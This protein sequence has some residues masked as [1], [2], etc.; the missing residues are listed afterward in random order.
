MSEL[1]NKSGRK[2]ET[3]SN[4]QNESFISFLQENEVDDIDLQLNYQ[5]QTIDQEESDVNFFK[6][7]SFLQNSEE[8]MKN[9]FSYQLYSK[10]SKYDNIMNVM[11]INNAE[12]EENSI[13][14]SS[15]NNKVTI[16]TYD[17][18][19]RVNPRKNL[20]A[21]KS[22]SFVGKINLNMKKKNNASKQNK[23]SKTPRIINQ[24]LTRRS[25]LGE[26]SDKAKLHQQ[27]KKTVTLNKDFK[28]KDLKNILKEN[29]YIKEKKL[30]IDNIKSLNF[31]SFKSK[32]ALKVHKGDFYDI[33][34]QANMIRSEDSN[35][36]CNASTS[37]SKARKVVNNA[38]SPNT[39]RNK[40]QAFLSRNTN[41]VHQ[42]FFNKGSGYLKDRSESKGRNL[43]SSSKREITESQ[44][45]DSPQHKKPSRKRNL[46]TSNRELH[47]SIENKS[48]YKSG[49][50][51]ET[52]TSNID[53][54]LNVKPKVQANDLTQSNEQQST[55]NFTEDTFLKSSQKREKFRDTN[56]LKIT[57]S[58]LY[59]NVTNAS[60]RDSYNTINEINQD[61][62]NLISINNCA[63]SLV[64]QHTKSNNYTNNDLTGE[65]GSVGNS[66]SLIKTKTNDNS[67]NIYS[68]L[69]KKNINIP[70]YGKNMTNRIN[71]D[72]IFIKKTPKYNYM[73]ENMLLFSSTGK[74]PLLLSKDTKDPLMIYNNLPK[75]PKSTS[76]SAKKTP[77]SMKYVPLENYKNI[78]HSPIIHANKDKNLITTTTSS[79]N[80]IILPL[81]SKDM[82]Q[83]LKNK[84]IKT[85]PGE[86]N[87]S[88]FKVNLTNLNTNIDETE[89]DLDQKVQLSESPKLRKNDFLNTQKREN[90]EK[91]EDKM[92]QKNKDMAVSLYTQ[93]FIEKSGKPDKILQTSCVDKE[94]SHQDNYDQSKKEQNESQKSRSINPSKRCSIKKLSKEFLANSTKAITQLPKTEGSV[95]NKISS[96]KIVENK[97]EKLTNKSNE[98]SQGRLIASKSTNKSCALGQKAKSKTSKAFPAYTNQFNKIFSNISY[99]PKKE[100]LHNTNFQSKKMSTPKDLNSCKNLTVIPEIAKEIVRPNTGYGR[101]QTTSVYSSI[102]LNVNSSVNQKLSSLKKG[103]VVSDELILNN[104]N[105][106]LNSYTNRRRNM[107]QTL[108]KNKK[109]AK[110]IEKDLLLSSNQISNDFMPEKSSHT[111]KYNAN[112]FSSKNVNK[113]G[114]NNSMFRS[115]NKE[116][117]SKK[118]GKDLSLGI[119]MEKLLRNSVGEKVHMKNYY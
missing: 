116:I 99:Q 15:E 111:P 108:T 70:G 14:I 109:I 24:K 80:S 117:M 53:L 106:N 18:D 33:Q 85:D 25:P 16:N 45:V 62:T 91:K 47:K 38:L 96:K 93:N 42:A 8:Q 77:Y 82:Y 22:T 73:N 1:Q 9:L 52:L 11:H 28:K 57:T 98:K 46:T 37:D 41:H 20:I 103:D 26:K 2:T 6:R 27:S 54:I 113:K 34:R 97:L 43:I 51:E 86:Q 107:E 100:Y 36:K 35:K 21:N 90:Q 105:N 19:I 32:E 7:D 61:N 115:V 49:D 30:S 101:Q 13:S 75:S 81:N 88:S 78:S 66:S 58:F 44:D 74:I 110:S 65:Y 17:S 94:L 40:D 76:Q 3:N 83:I 104:A 29:S 102:N 119:K 84:N 55:Q 4:F 72:E 64:E 50:I 68:S 39:G 60:N 23:R 89:Y 92:V 118:L 87:V 48:K 114:P 69:R 95:Q 71:K 79:K 12:N 31:S 59:N 56:N 112:T 67:T 5:A 63:D 10:T